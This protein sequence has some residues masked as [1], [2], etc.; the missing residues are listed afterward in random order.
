MEKK[1]NFDIDFVEDIPSKSKKFKFFDPVD[2]YGKYIFKHLSKII[3]VIAFVIAGI[4]LLAGIAIGYIIYKSQAL[5][6]AISFGVILVFAIFSVILF[7][8][9]YAIGHILEQN[10]QILSKLD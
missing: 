9:V 1:D 2:I 7:F 10:N 8:L 4:N 5:F 3:K 6:V